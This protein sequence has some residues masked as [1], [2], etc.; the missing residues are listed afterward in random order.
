[1]RWKTF[2]INNAR[3]PGFGKLHPFGYRSG[4]VTHFYYIIRT[5]GC[6]RATILL[7]HLSLNLAAF[8]STV[9][10]GS[11]VRRGRRERRSFPNEYYQGFVFAWC[12]SPLFQLP[13]KSN[14]GPSYGVGSNGWRLWRRPI[15]AQSRRFRES[16]VN[17][18]RFHN[19]KRIYTLEMF[20]LYVHKIICNLNLINFNDTFTIFIYFISSLLLYARR[21]FFNLLKFYHI[22]YITIVR[23]TRLNMQKHN[24]YIKVIT[25]N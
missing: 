3:R 2:Y 23:N 10:I 14:D 12:M 13:N 18:I 7:G 25:W 5:Y 4:R 20:N 21:P 19:F 8:W 1:M 16:R 22:H 17:V 11:V 9:E 15:C 6:F 24:A